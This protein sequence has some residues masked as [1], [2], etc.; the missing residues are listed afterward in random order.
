M[1]TYLLGLMPLSGIGYLH[2]REVRMEGFRDRL[3]EMELAI[4]LLKNDIAL[5]RMVVVV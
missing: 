4:Y 5:E 1:D 2:L 3:N